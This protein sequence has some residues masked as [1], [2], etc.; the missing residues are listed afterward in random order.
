MELIF[1]T[2]FTYDFYLISEIGFKIYQ[3]KFKNQIFTTEINYEAKHNLW[4]LKVESKINLIFWSLLRN[5][6]F[7]LMI[8][9]YCI[10]FKRNSFILPLRPVKRP[11]L[12][13]PFD[14]LLF[15]HYD[16]KNW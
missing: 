6:Y 7:I 11:S 12:I 2:Y 14:D 4:N 9:Y 5:F 3:Y 16:K 13:V 8:V 10:G 15:L 1:W